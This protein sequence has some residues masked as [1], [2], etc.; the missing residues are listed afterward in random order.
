MERLKF[1]GKWSIV[2]KNQNGSKDFLRVDTNNESVEFEI[3]KLSDNE[4]VLQDTFRISGE[5]I[6]NQVFYKRIKM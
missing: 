5:L 2:G 1:K 4:L 3:F 6:R